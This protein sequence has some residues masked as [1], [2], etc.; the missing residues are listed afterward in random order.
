MVKMFVFLG[1]PGSQYEKTRHNVGWMC[2]DALHLTQTWQKKFHAE[3]I[4]EPGGMLYAKPQTFMNNSGQSVSEI[5][6]FFS[7]TPDEIAVVHDDLELPFGAIKFQFDG[8][9]QGHNGL[10]SIK[11]HL[12][13]SAFYRL[14]IGIGRPSKGEVSSYVLSRFSPEEEIFLPHIIESA[15]TLVTHIPEHIPFET[16]PIGKP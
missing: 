15:S 12:G 2:S 3:Y 13:T 5:S 1:N 11:Q 4:R 16:W 7:L 8:G 10:K 9:L 14:R 6:R